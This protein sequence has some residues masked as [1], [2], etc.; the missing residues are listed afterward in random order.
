[1]KDSNGEYFAILA[2]VCR[3]KR[4]DYPPKWADRLQHKAEMTEASVFKESGSSMKEYPRDACDEARKATARSKFDERIEAALPAPPGRQ[5][6]GPLG[7]LPN[8]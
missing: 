1:M 3:I 7:V 2:Q 8:E 6:S 4:G 5:M